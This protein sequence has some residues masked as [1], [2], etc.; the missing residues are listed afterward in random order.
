MDFK[1]VPLYAI[2]ALCS[3][4]VGLMISW[5]REKH[6]SYPIAKAPGLKLVKELL[7]SGNSVEFEIMFQKDQFFF[8]S[9]FHCSVIGISFK[10]R[11]DKKDESKFFIAIKRDKDKGRAIVSYGNS[12]GE[13]RPH[14]SNSLKF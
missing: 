2:I 8:Q 14:P 13:L 10:G 4:V 1:T 11:D 5:L 12:D 9:T 7:A 3:I 6:R